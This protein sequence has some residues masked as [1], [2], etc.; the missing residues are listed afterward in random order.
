MDAVENRLHLRL[1]KE[2][3]TAARAVTMSSFAHD[4]RHLNAFIATKTGAQSVLRPQHCPGARDP[5]GELMTTGSDFLS[6]RLDETVQM[7]SLLH[8]KEW[9]N[10]SALIMTRWFDYR[11]MSPLKLTLMFGAIYNDKLRCHI[12][13][14][15]DLERAESVNGVKPGLP[16]ER[17]TWFTAL[18]KARQRAD[19]FFLPYDDYIEFCFDFSSRRKRRWTML[20]SQL[21]PSANNKEAWLDR[22]EKFYDDR[23]PLVMRRV[24]SI[25]QYRLENDL[26]LPP[27]IDFRRIMLS[28]L[29]FSSRRM[30]DQ[31]AE[32]VY[33][34]RHLSLDAAINLVSS[35]DRAEVA[36]RARSDFDDGI[37]S[38]E[39]TVLLSAEQ[40]LPGCFGLTETVSLSCSPCLNCPLIG[41]CKSVGAE[42]MAITQ[43]LTG[44]PS[45]VWQADKE[46]NARNT[47]NSRARKEQALVNDD[48]AGT[49]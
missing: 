15:V 30:S 40:Q 43:Q 5:E 38:E 41:K 29:S 17:V 7:R 21:H 31:I 10:E 33:A 26:G 45:P 4:L 14:H 46:R 11:F 24:G 32:R 18:W 36:S 22:F 3:D 12:R 16:N 20:P 35:E 6:Q 48:T 1:T 34:K 42:A 19:E 37:W 23:V 25:P 8:P 39:P 28:E 2:V 44:S 47:A 13:R 49:P 9:K 27:Q